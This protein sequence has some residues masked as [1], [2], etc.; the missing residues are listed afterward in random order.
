MCR[1]FTWV[2]SFSSTVFTDFLSDE[3]AV[4]DYLYQYQSRLR[5]RYLTISAALKQACIPFEPANGCLFVWLD[6]SFWLKYFEGPDVPEALD[7]APRK[8]IIT[9][10][11]KL[12]RQLIKHGVFLSAGEVSPIQFQLLA[13]AYL[14]IASLGLQRTNTGTLSICVHERG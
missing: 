3:A 2:T 8:E 13:N 10:E 11:R 12:S 5:S 9:R 14:L 4:D 6:L 1:V 7:R